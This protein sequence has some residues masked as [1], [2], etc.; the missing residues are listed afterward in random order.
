MLGI[1]RRAWRTRRPACW[2][3]PTGVGAGDVERDPIDLEL[4]GPDARY[5]D[6]PQ[7]SAAG[8]PPH[9]VQPHA[10]RPTGPETAAAARRLVLAL[11]VLVLVGWGLGEACVALVGHADLN[12]VRELAAQRSRG[13]NALTRAL[14]WVG[15]ALVIVPLAV[16][17]CALLN[18]LGR[19]R[20]AVAIAV[21]LGGAILLYRCVKLLVARPRPPVEHLQAVT[22]AS[23]PSGHATQSSAFYFA[24]LLALLAARPRPMLSAAAVAG[25][26]ALVVAIAASRVY[27]GVHYP[28]DVVFGVLL[29]MGWAAL[30]WSSIHAATPPS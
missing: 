28:S 27:L 24:L 14:S 3:D 13:L 22:G 4:A 15:S 12:A 2:G 5:Y 26:I 9:A 8:P 17:C 10:R 30:V 1:E 25:A 29:G 6:A 21:S 23:F 18:H 11:V 7:M 19:T 20:D 16:A